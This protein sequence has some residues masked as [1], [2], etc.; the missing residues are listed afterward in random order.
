MIFPLLSIGLG[1]AFLIMGIAGTY[2]ILAILGIP[3]PGVD[4]ITNEQAKKGV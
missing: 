4:V 1:V 2:N 3:L